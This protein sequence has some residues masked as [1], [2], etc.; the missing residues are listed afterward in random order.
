MRPMKRHAW[1]EPD[2]LKERAFEIRY[3]LNGNAVPHYALAVTAL[4][5]SLGWIRFPEIIFDRKWQ[6][7]RSI[8]P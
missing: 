2:T 1:Y 4:S 8:G 6:K 7:I 3:P 5:D